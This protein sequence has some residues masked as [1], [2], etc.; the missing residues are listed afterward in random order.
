MEMIMNP[1]D[2]RAKDTGVHATLT[3]TAGEILF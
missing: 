3:E 1:E 2:I